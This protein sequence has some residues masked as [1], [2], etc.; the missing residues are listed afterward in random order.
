[1]RNDVVA[2][3]ASRGAKPHQFVAIV[4]LRAYQTKE[5]NF[6]SSYRSGLWTC[7]QG[8]NGD[9]TNNQGTGERSA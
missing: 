2:I 6:L 7:A 1:M 9:R 8:D 5:M 3:V 4:A